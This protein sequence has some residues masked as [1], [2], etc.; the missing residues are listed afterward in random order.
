MNLEI[1]KKK[2][3]LLFYV[4]KCFYQTQLNFFGKLFF[5]SHLC[6]M[7]FLTVCIFFTQKG[8]DILKE[9][10]FFHLKTYIIKVT[11]VFHLI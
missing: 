10:D 8:A 1:N 5:A 6:L 4:F 7:P 2:L 9:H 11:K 3:P